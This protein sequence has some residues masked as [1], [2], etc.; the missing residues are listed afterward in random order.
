MPASTSHRAA[1]VPETLSAPVRTDP[2]VATPE[3]R[4]FEQWDDPVRGRLRFCTLFSG[5]ATPTRELTTGFA[6]VPVGGWLG[7]HRH[8]ASETYF[9]L[10]GEGVVTLEGQEHLVRRESTVLIPGDTEHGV[11]NTGD[12]ELRFF[13]V[14][15]AHAMSD[16]RY[17]FRESDGEAGHTGQAG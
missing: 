16:I 7:L 9:V 5:D 13:Y 1:S 4:E 14:F 15:A 11:R 3:D 2:F 12:G 6:V 10:E 8:T 17:R